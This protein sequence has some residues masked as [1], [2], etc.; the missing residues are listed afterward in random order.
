MKFKIFNIIIYISFPKFEKVTI[1]DQDY[2]LRKIFFKNE[3]KIITIPSL[4]HIP[5]FLSFNFTLYLLS[6]LNKIRLVKARSVLKRIYYYYILS[7]LDYSKTKIVI[8]YID[9]SGIFNNLNKYDKSKKRKYFAVQNGARHIPCVTTSLPK[10][11]KITLENLFCFGKRDIGLFKKYSHKIANFH[12]V[13][14]IKSSFFFKKDLNTKK[15]FDIC[16]ISQWKSKF[17]QQDYNNDFENKVSKELKASID[18]LMQFLRKLSL[19]NKYKIIVCLRTKGNEEINY[20][21][22]KLKNTNFI[23]VGGDTNKFSAFKTVLKSELTIALNSTTLS[24][25]FGISKVL[26]TNILN[27]KNFQMPEAGISY[28]NKNN[29]VKFEDRVNHLLKLNIIKYK[30]ITKNNVDYMCAK[31][32][33]KPAH[34]TILQKIKDELNNI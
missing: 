29:F 10:G 15:V 24:E 16:L 3:K 11:Y 5:V 26:W 34:I 4:P 8:T 33:D 31:N 2:W 6:N 19:K 23:L 32:F 14:S 13:G 17:D 22:N 21:N 9:N 27:N 25:V 7:I 20:Y 12:P 30:K 1:F 28:F 18:I